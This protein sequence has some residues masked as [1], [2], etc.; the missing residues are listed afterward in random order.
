MKILQKVFVLALISMMTLTVLVAAE[1]LPVT[2]VVKGPP[3]DVIYLDAKTSQDVGIGDVAAGRSDILLWSA[4]EAVYKRLPLGILQSLNLIRTASGYW[5]LV[6]NPLQDDP[7][8]PGVA[9]SS[10]DNKTHF[11][12]FALREVRYQMNWLLNRKY[13]I[14]EILASGGA[15]MYSPVQPSEP[16]NTKVESTYADLDLTDVGNEADALSE[17]NAT[18]FDTATTLAGLGY[19]L[20]LETDATGTWW[21]FT[22]PGGTKETVEVVFYIRIEDERHEEGLHIANLIEKANIRVN[23]QEK[24]RAIASPIIYSSDPKA[25]KWNIYTEGWVSMAEW[26]YPEWSIAQM[27]A[28][29]YGFMPGRQRTGWWQYTNDTID[30]ISLKTVYGPV[31]SADEY[32]NSIAEVVE[33]GIQ[34]SVRVFVAESWEYFP[35]NPRVTNLAYGTVSGLWPMW[36]L[37]TATTPDS[38]LRATEFSAAGVLFMSSWNP[39]GGFEDVYSELIWRYLRDYADYTH[40]QTAEPI[41]VRTTQDT[42]INNVTQANIDVPSTAVIYNATTNSWQAVGAGKKAKAKIVFNY[43]LSNWHHGKMMTIA[44][45]MNIWGFMWE[46]A[47]EDYPGDPYYHPQ[48]SSLISPTL[49]EVKGIQIINSTAIAVYGTYTHSVSNAVTADFYAVWPTLPWEVYAAMEYVIVKGG[50]VSTKTYGWYDGEADRWIDMLIPDHVTDI[51]EAMNILKTQGYVSNYTKVTGYTPSASAGQERYTAAIN[52]ATTYK[53]VAISNG[54]FWLK[55]YDPTIS[56]MELRAF[57]D[58]TYPFGPGYWQAQL[59][60]SRMS[61]RRVDAPTEISIGESIPINVYPILKVEFPVHSEEPASTGYVEATLKNPAG[62]VVYTSAAEFVT[63]GLFSV[64]VPSNV[65]Q[66]LAGGIYSIAVSAAVEKGLYPETK[67]YPITITKPT[68][69][70]TIGVFPFG[71]GQT[72]PGVGTTT[73]EI[74]TSV[75]VTATSAEGYEFYYWALDGVPYTNA[76]TISVTMD[77]VH[78]LVAYFS[79]LAAAPPPI[80]PETLSAIALIVAIIAVIVAVFL[81]TKFLPGKKAK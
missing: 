54:P 35:V 53:H 70:L 43:M 22:P 48:Y 5:S 63:P 10:T 25:Y 4:S 62:G 1:P 23:R 50:P 28:P 51:K 47:S 45:V 79:A 9:T 55:T 65:T 61:I 41:P 31:E 69:A 15:P 3:L 18:M 30:E 16:A 33:L 19:T 75:T 12:P 60:L 38:I 76:T 6:F 2:Q 7:S 67:T 13:I 81:P 17:I 46:W 66:P 11:N 32:W 36:P 37:R 74:G 72:S 52:W 40:P 78:G 80:G 34:E 29:W 57:R 71:T 73:Y 20:A 21:R 44:D 39:V 14:E 58:Q 24:T 49:D 26:L 56:Y 8:I 42:T 68:Y 59:F 64:T 27:Y 77:K